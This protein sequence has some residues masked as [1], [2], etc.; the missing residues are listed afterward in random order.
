[1]TAATSGD[2]IIRRA[3][4]AVQSPA[5]D[6]CSHAPSRVVS[7][8][9][10]FAF[11]RGRPPATARLLRRTSWTV[12]T[13]AGHTTKVLKIG[14]SAVRPRPWPPYLTCTNDSLLDRFCCVSSSFRPGI[15][16][17]VSVDNGSPLKSGHPSMCRLGT[18]CRARVVDMGRASGATTHSDLT[19]HC[20]GI[21]IV[22]HVAESTLIAFQGAAYGGAS[23]LDLHDRLTCPSGPT[24]LSARPPLCQ[25]LVRHDDHVNLCGE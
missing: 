7:I 17:A 2:Q 8:S 14:R 13:G 19:R 16:L 15:F 20:R 23:M 21:T 5:T 18:T 10:S 24:L 25:T 4:G 11:V 12:P 6:D 1:M 22:L 3:Q 9:V